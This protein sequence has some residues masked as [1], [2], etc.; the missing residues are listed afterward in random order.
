MRFVSLCSVS[1]ALIRYVR[2]TLAEQSG[3]MDA[4]MRK[5]EAKKCISRAFGTK[6]PTR[7]LLWTVSVLIQ[8][9]TEAI[10][11]CPGHRSPPQW[12]AGRLSAR[13]PPRTAPRRRT[14][15]AGPTWGTA[16][17]S[18]P[19][20]VRVGL[21]NRLAWREWTRGRA[22]KRNTHLGDLAVR[23][24]EDAGEGV[25]KATAVS[26]EQAAG[27]VHVRSQLEH[28]LHCGAQHGNGQKLVTRWEQLTEI[29]Q[30]V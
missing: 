28:L 7:N 15:A 24:E 1:A 8:S 25:R 9:R 6:Q 3:Y 19:A 30:F 18:G 11:Q 22:S 20:N 23:G 12:W 29:R 13:W 26:G 10:P 4:K 27:L 14:P 2:D 17:R 21:V 5:E 16:S